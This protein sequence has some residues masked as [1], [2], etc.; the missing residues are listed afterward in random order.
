[1]FDNTRVIAIEE[2]YWDPEMARAFPAGENK[3]PI[4]DLLTEI[5]DVRLRAMDAAGIDVQVLSHGAPAAQKLSPG[6]AVELTQRVNDR[7]AE[8]CARHPGRFAAFA[9]LPTPVPDQAARELERC[10]KD[11]K[12]KG[13]MIHGL[14]NGLFIDDKRFWPIFEVAEKLDVPIYLHPSVP[15]A[16]VTKHY[17][18]DYARDFPTVIRPAWGFTVETATAAIRLILS[19]ALEKYPRLQIILGHLG[20]T[21]PFL[22]WRIDQ[23]LSRPGQQSLSFRKQFCEHFHVTTSGNFSTPALICTM[24]E[25]GIDR[26]MFAVDYPYVMNQDGMDWIKQLQLSPD[27]K[28]KL[29]SNNAARL[30]KL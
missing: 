18:D 2:H 6:I 19:R 30:L 21:L 16:E 15:H 1:M 10:I 29:I 22:L 7:L 28:G 4:A 8:A 14:T 27:D 23:A 3:S 13:A 24:L 5:G 20:E 26:I 11:L 25:L 9:A 17:Y 12:F